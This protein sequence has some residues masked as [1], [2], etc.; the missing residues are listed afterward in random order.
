M[1]KLILF[2]HAQA[3]LGSQNYDQLSEL[4][5]KQSLWLGQHL[6]NHA[7]L[8]DRIIS[9][10]LKRHQQTTLGIL[11]GMNSSIEF[12]QNDAWNEFQFEG[13]VKAYLKQHPD[14][15]PT[16]KKSN[17]F[18]RLLKVAMLD[19]SNDKL[20]HHQGESWAEFENRVVSAFLALTGN[21]EKQTVWLISSGGVI[22]MLLSYILETS[23]K[24][25]I[26]LNLQT[27]NTSIS[28]VLYKPDSHCLMSYNQVPHLQSSDRQ[29]AITYA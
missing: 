7:A 3:S 11:K 15:T 22:S 24:S 18:F 4:G 14:K 23:K 12:E 8:P 27:R 9:G 1:S 19:W 6:K 13:I 29:Q 20:A 10:S 21:T 28:E 5:F 2:R 26:E 17:S 25:M 16:D